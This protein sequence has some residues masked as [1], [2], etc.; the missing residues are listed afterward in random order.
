MVRVSPAMLDAVLP[1][2]WR[3]PWFGTTVGI[4]WSGILDAA[5]TRIGQD[6]WSLFS[7][8]F[9]LMLFKGVL[10]SM[11]GPAPSYD[12]QRI[13]SARTPKDAAKQSFFVSVVLA[14]P[15]YMLV[16]G[17]TVLAL[18]FFVPQL[19]AMGEAVDFELILPLAM[20]DFIPTGLLGL[21]IAAL[22]AAFMGTYAATVNAA[23]AYLV[24]DIYR[25]YI[26]PHAEERTYVRMSYA[27]SLAVVVVGAVIGLF[28]ASVNGIV[29]WIV[30]A[31]FGGYTAANLLKWYWW[32]FNAYG[33]FWGMMGGIVASV[34][35]PAVLPDVTPLYVFPIILAVSLVGCVG[36]SL[37]TRP[38]DE[39]VLKTFYLRVR[40]WGAWGPIHALVAREHPGVQPNRG[41]AR[42]AFN[43][44][45]GIVWQTAL[46]ATGIFLVL[47]DVRATTVCLLLVLATS[48][49]L[50]R[51]WYDRL[52][53]HPA[54]LPRDDALR[55]APERLLAARAA[56]A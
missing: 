7:V 5:N 53:D 34:L 41:F 56:S 47:R 16:T 4:D 9:T 10:Q 23:P 14:I 50:K 36:G 17:L 32:R 6:G 26:D 31:L 28:V 44:A 20:R 40:P 35:V 27:A 18:A 25:R 19:R 46:T 21:L 43:V 55:P 33:Y 3:S 11:A 37:L 29:Q 1:A 48:L 39:A 49:I 13:L 30:A 15:R 52:E 22:L 54:D 42:D 45:V 2:G 24:N 12:M 8:F 51:S 38:D